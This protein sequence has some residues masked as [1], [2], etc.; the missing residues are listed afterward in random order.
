MGVASSPHVGVPSF[1]CAGSGGRWVRTGAICAASG[2]WCGG[3]AWRACASGGRAVPARVGAGLV[4]PLWRALPVCSP[5]CP[6]LRPLPL[7]HGPSPFLFLAPCCVAPGVLSL[8][9]PACYLGPPLVLLPRALPLPFPFPVWWWWGGRGGPVARRWPMPGGGRSGATGGRLGGVGGVEALDH[10]P[11]ESFPCR[12]PHGGLQGGR[13]AVGG[14]AG[15]DLR[16]RVHDVYPFSPSHSPGPFHPAAEPPQGRG[17]PPG[18][19]GGG[20]WG[21]EGSELEVL[22]RRWWGLGVEDAYGCRGERKAH[23]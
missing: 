4:L 3:A 23:C 17:R 1:P 8:W 12:L 13:V 15:A 16:K 18:E 21:G 9:A 20:F 2:P 19:V 7:C 11:E 5:W 22:E 10:V 6:P 14:G